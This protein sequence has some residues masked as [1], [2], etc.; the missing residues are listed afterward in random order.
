MT[1]REKQPIDWLSEKELSTVIHQAE[2]VRV[3]AATGDQ[4][5][6]K[7]YQEALDQVLMETRIFEENFVDKFVDEEEIWSQWP[8]EKIAGVAHLYLMAATIQQS[9]MQHT[10]KGNRVKEHVGKEAGTWLEVAVAL[11]NHLAKNDFLKTV[12]GSPFLWPVEL[13]RS[14]ARLTERMPAR[15]EARINNLKTA[16]GLYDEAVAESV[17]ICGDEKYDSGTRETGRMAAG[18]ARVEAVLSR[19]EVERSG[20][21]GV[22]NEALR[23]EFGTALGELETSWNNG[24]KNWDRFDAGLARMYKALSGRSELSDL[25]GSIIERRRDLLAEVAGWGDETAAKR[26]EEFEKALAKPSK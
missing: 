26:L 1:E 5:D 3:A 15:G 11:G 23:R 18:T 13:R 21:E 17:A 25:Q 7:K 10:L 22:A 16:A 19:L 2:E 12:D 14:Q 24:Y 20:G 4:Y 6:D 8:L 9:R